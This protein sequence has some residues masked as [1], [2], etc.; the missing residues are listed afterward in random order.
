MSLGRRAMLVGA[1]AVAARPARAVDRSTLRQLA[2]RAAIYLTPF[3]RMFARRHHDAVEQGRRLNS[4]TWRDRPVDGVLAGAAWLDL[5]VGPL[6]LTLPPMGERFYSAAF[7]DPSTNVFGHVSSRVSGKTPPPCMI[8]GPSWDGVAESDVTPLRAPASTM[9]L[10]LRIAV[11]DSE[12][13][14]EIVRNLQAR[15]LLETPD[16]RNERRI[17]EMRELMRFRTDAPPEPIVDWDAPRPGE[18]FDL[19]DTGLAFLADCQLSESDRETLDGLAALRLHAGR[20]F[21][22]RAFADAERDAIAAGLADA[23]VEIATAGPSFGTV[24]NGWRYPGGN[25]GRFGTEYLYRA[26]IAT[27]GLGAP[28]PAESLD[29]VAEVDGQFEPPSPL[30]ARAVRWLAERR[31]ARFFQPDAELLDGRYHLPAPRAAVA[32]T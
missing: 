8:G 29:L 6:F 5:S 19:F 20:R 14:L 30:P 7:I 24:V 31:I 1:T 17:L 9:W 11:E 32:P 3:S 12:R 27:T 2:R 23:A 21:D 13:D 16:K 26:F 28:V 15:S 22:A 25:L 10:R 4:L 18:R